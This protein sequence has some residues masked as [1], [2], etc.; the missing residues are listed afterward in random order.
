M[1]IE[2]IIF[3][4]FLA[5]VFAGIIGYEREVNQSNAGLKPTY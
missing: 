2:K 4:L 3:R 1:L 5:V